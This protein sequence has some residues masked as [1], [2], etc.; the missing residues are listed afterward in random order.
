MTGTEIGLFFAVNIVLIML[1]LLFGW[2]QWGWFFTTL[3]SGDIKF[4]M[5]SKKLHRIIHDV[6]GMKLVNGKFVPGEENKS[7]LN[8]RFGLYWIGWPPFSA[9]HHFMIPKETENADGK[10]AEQWIIDDGETEVNSLR[11]TFPRPY[12]LRATEL[13]DN[14]PADVLISVKLEVVDPY[15]P[16]FQYK[17]R[18]FRNAGSIIRAE[19]ITLLAH[20]NYDEF[21]VASKGEADGILAPLKDPDGELNKKLIEQVGVRL[22]G[23]SIPQYDPS[24]DNM[25][26][27]TVAKAVARELGD[28]KITEATKNGEAT[29]I[30]ADANA[31]AQERLA[32]ARGVRI[33]ETTAA[34]AFTNASG[35]EVVK[36]VSDILR[37]EALAGPDSKITTLVDGTNA[38]AVVP[39][40]GEKK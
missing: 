26:K 1:I 40:G 23:I 35:A 24:D 3:E 20:F 38:P 17:G 28:A 2:W 7:F 31:R 10:S 18:F 6:R 9:V 12:I 19:A 27:A 34:L 22:V 39:V 15:V 8:N 4:I 11:Y 29:V 37:A 36:A 13:G 33:K 30:S 16:V 14:I 5:R 21:V 25:R 32:A